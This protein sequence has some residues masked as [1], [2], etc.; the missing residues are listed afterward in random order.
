MFIVDVLI[1][2]CS[3]DQWECSKDQIIQGDVPIIIKRLGWK[4]TKETKEELRDSEQH[5]FVE[6][7]QNHLWNSDV[8]PMTMN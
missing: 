3:N 1:K 4:G 2:G 8:I 7:V 5:V 6:E